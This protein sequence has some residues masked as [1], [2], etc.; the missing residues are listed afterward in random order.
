MRY[1]PAVRTPYTLHRA[2]QVVV[3]DNIGVVNNQDF[4]IRLECPTNNAL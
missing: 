2:P 4:G 3:Q 1:R